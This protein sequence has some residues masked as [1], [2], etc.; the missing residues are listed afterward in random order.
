[1]QALGG[2]TYDLVMLL[3][4]LGQLSFEPPQGGWVWDIRNRGLGA[5][6]KAKV[7]YVML[8]RLLQ[9][10]SQEV[11]VCRHGSRAKCGF[12]VAVAAAAAAV[13]CPVCADVVEGPL[14]AVLL[15]DM[16]F[17]TMQVQYYTG[18][19]QPARSNIV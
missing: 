4:H 5:C 13:C 2:T 12:P 14:L 7:G 6:V 9:D 10:I 1:V 8:L 15:A 17:M 19:T 18:S 3:R 11:H 16:P